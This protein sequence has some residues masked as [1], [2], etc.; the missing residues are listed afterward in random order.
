[1]NIGGARSIGESAQVQANQRQARVASDRHLGE[2]ANR[3]ASNRRRPPNHRVRQSE[4]VLC[5]DL[6]CVY[7]SKR[8]TCLWYVL[9]S[10]RKEV[11]YEREI[12]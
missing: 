1:M 11:V 7:E 3:C 6:G 9:R 12:N 8:P 4:Y 2:I 10:T 5:P